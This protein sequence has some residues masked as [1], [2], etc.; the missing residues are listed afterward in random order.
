[1]KR[2]LGLTSAVFLAL[3]AGC[4][5]TKDFPTPGTLTSEVLLALIGQGYVEMI[6]EEESMPSSQVTIVSL[7]DGNV[8]YFPGFK[9]V[10]FDLTEYVSP[11]QPKEEIQVSIEVKGTQKATLSFLAK[12]EGNDQ[13][14]EEKMTDK[15]ITTD[16]TFVPLSLK[17]P[18]TLPT[19]PKFL[20]GI[21]SNGADFYIRKLHV[22]KLPTSSEEA[23]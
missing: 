18:D 6:P 19:S 2:I 4:L 23:Q 7:S 22:S 11:L 16:W 20:F 13:T 8:L 9:E 5:L 17:V 3:T 10:R 1:M 14:V 21:K 15:E 12:L